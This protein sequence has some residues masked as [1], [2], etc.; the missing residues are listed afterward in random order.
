MKSLD[1]EFIVVNDFE[2]WDLLVLDDEGSELKRLPGTGK[3][4]PGYARAIKTRYSDDSDYILWM[5]SPHDMSIVD[6]GDFSEQYLSNFWNY[7]GHDVYGTSVAANDDASKIVGIGFVPKM[8]CIQTL[9]LWESGQEIAILE[10]R[11]LHKHV[12]A[13]LSVELS[14]DGKTIFVGGA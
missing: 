2:G 7:K 8:N 12:A 1:K 4:A 5:K 6:M 11:Q 3:G 9:H 14:Q 10:M 13:W